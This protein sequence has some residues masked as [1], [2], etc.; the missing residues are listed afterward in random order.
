MECSFIEL[1]EIVL[2]AEYV[3]EPFLR[4][5]MGFLCV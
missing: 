4:V 3:Y 2:L 5:Q 1:F